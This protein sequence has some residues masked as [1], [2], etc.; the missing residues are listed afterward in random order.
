MNYSVFWNGEEKAVSTANINEPC[1]NSIT[2]QEFALFSVKGS[3]KLIKSMSGKIHIICRHIESFVKIIIFS[4]MLQN[5]RGFSDTFLPHNADKPAFP[6]D[7][8]VKT[9]EIVHR[10]KRELYA[11]CIVDLN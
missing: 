3:G 11:E 4:D 2:K 6:F 10:D 9:A 7:L 1:Y 5:H 8:F